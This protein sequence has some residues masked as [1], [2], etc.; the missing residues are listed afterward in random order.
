M[1]G[2]ANTPYTSLHTRAN[3]SHIKVALKDDTRGL[4]A[5]I[6]TKHEDGSTT[7]LDVFQ[8]LL[9]RLNG[10]SEVELETQQKTISDV[11]RSAFI[12]RRWGSLRFVGGG[13][14]VSDDL[15][16]LSKKQ[17]CPGKSDDKA[18]DASVRDAVSPSEL[19]LHDTRVASKLSNAQR[20]ADKAERKLQRKLRRKARQKSRDEEL[21][22][23]PTMMLPDIRTSR[24]PDGEGE[25]TPTATTS[26]SIQRSKAQGSPPVGRNAVRNRYIQHKKMSLMDSKALNE[27][28]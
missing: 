2:A 19:S 17:T 7:G 11:R 13:L 6:V 16:E 25:K 3:A 23:L 28:D 15:Q 26:S 22:S 10:K 14:L 12:S 18:G 27:V 24:L 20:K 8:N 21:T 4:G 1:L 9:G 5:E